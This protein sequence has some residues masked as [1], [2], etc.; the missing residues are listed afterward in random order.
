MNDAGPAAIVAGQ[1][2]GGRRRI[3]A[4]HL[5]VTNL[6]SVGALEAITQVCAAELD[7]T[8]VTIELLGPEIVVPAVLPLA[9]DERTGQRLVGI[10]LGHSGR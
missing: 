4:R 7:G 10:E 2:Q 5:P 9:R 6:R 8:D 1:S 3:R